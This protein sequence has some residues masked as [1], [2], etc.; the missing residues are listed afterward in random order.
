M[1]QIQQMVL[2]LCIT[3]LDQALQDNKY[4]SVVIS[5]IVVLGMQDSKGWLN[6]E[7]YT[8]IYSAAIKLAWLMV[9]QEVYYQQQMEIEA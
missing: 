2:Q 3:M 7:D 4:K 5:S 1:K 9:V 6:T 8:L